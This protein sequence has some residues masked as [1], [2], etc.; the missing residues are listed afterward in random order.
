MIVRCL[1]LNTMTWQED[2]VFALLIILVVNTRGAEDV[3]AFGLVQFVPE[4]DNLL[5][6]HAVAIDLVLS[7]A[8]VDLGCAKHEAAHF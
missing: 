2:S 4:I 1:W 5:V 7:T 6:G 8:D 3:L